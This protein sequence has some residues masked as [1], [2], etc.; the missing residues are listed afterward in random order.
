MSDTLRLESSIQ[1]EILNKLKKR[2]NSFSYKHPPQPSG[3]PDIHHIENGVSYWFEVKRSSKHKATKLQLLRH[4]QLRKAG[5]VVF[6]VWS[7]KQVK[8]ILK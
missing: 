5:S 2:D 4:K 8:E 6:V 1:T 7:W 3:I